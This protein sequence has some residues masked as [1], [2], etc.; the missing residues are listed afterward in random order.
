MI[1][2]KFRIETSSLLKTAMI[3]S[4]VLFAVPIMARGATGSTLGAS[5]STGGYR[6]ANAWDVYGGDSAAA[7]SSWGINIIRED[8]PDFDVVP[9]GTNTIQADG[10]YLHGLQS[11]VNNNS[12]AGD[13]TILCPF[14][15]SGSQILG[16]TPSQTSYWNAYNDQLTAM[17][18]QFAGQSNVWLEVWNEPYA[19]NTPTAD[20]QW[21]SDMETM[22][23]SIRD[24]TGFTGNIVI[25]GGQEAGSVAPVVADGS[26]LVQYDPQHN[27]VFDL[28]AYNSWFSTGTS[29]M[30]SSIASVQNAGVKMIFGEYG[31][32][33]SAG[34]YNVSPFLQAATAKNVGAIAWNWSD[35]DSDTLHNSDG[36]LN[37]STENYNW[38]SQVLNYTLGTG[39]AALPSTWSD[40]DIGAPSISGAGS[41]SKGVFTVFGSGSDIWNVSDQFN[42]V[43]RPLTG[44]GAISAKVASQQNTDAWAKAGVMFRDSAAADAQFVAVEL[45]PGNGVQMQARTAAGTDA[46]EIGSATVSGTIWVRLVKT[47]STFTGYYS[48]GLA[49]G[50]A[51]DWIEIGSVPTLDF[52]DSSFLVGLAVS[53]HDTSS[54][55]TASF[56][57][58]TVTPEPATIA[59]LSAG[60]LGV[61]QLRRRNK[62]IHSL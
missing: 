53:S 19:W 41:Y 29:G 23:N 58:V 33:T 48:T 46:I 15:W 44:N 37:D 14:T 26:A 62:R 28:H 25:P 43:S 35:A 31:W 18:K 21:L 9:M 57:D 22:V 4:C 61:W 2:R 13:T 45:T 20:G 30:E 24:G 17:A 47:G 32:S 59:L 5:T 27:L 54:I 1:T 7:M 60:M 49:Q 10:S 40:A 50:G 8:I 39:R 51:L 11:V 36:T 56:A 34:G 38:A 3:T 52:T 16:V 42:F 6:G 12:A 55:A